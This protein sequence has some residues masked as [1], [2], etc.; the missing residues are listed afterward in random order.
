MRPAEKRVIWG[1]LCVAIT[2]IAGI[3]VTLTAFNNP[4]KYAVAVAGLHD[5]LD[6]AVAAL[7]TEF[8]T[9]VVPAL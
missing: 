9:T 4:A 2:V 5:G 6:K 8:N 3:T 7:T 1:L